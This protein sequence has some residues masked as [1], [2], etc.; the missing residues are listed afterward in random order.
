[1][2][3]NVHHF[4]WKYKVSK[5][6]LEVRNIAD[7]A[8]SIVSSALMRKETRACHKREDFPNE[9]QDYSGISI[10]TKTNVPFIQEIK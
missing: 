3:E 10:Y 5:D 6:F 4:Y 2:K 1:M 7:V 8:S 9:S